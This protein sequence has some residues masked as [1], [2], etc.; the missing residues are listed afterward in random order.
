M[1][2]GIDMNT[3]EFAVR[4]GVPYALIFYESGTFD[5]D[6]NSVSQGKLRLGGGLPLAKFAVKK[7]RHWEKRVHLSQFFD[8]NDQ[9]WH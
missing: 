5:A 4:D 2:L 1:L 7:K 3:A 8:I 9:T 6:F